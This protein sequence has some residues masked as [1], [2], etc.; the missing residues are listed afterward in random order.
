MSK[1]FFVFMILVDLTL[2]FAFV[3]SNLLLWSVAN[4]PSYYSTG[5]GPVTIEIVPRPL[6]NGEP[7]PQVAFSII[8]YPF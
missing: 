2:G 8:N 7:T 5:W 6:V 4:Q 3:F 1:R